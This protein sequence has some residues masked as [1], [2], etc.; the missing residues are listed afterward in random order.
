MHENLIKSPAVEKVAAVYPFRATDYYLELIRDTKNPSLDP[1]GLQCI[2]SEKELEDR[3]SSEDPLAEDHLSPLP[4]IIHKYDDRIVLLATN[5]CAVHCRFCFRKRC[6]KDGAE[7]SDISEEEADNVCRWLKL[8]PRVREVLISGGD[9]LMLSDSK[10]AALLEKL[11]A[12]GVDIVRIGT[13]IPVV[14]PER[15]TENLAK[16]LASFPSIW[17]MT[18]FNHPNEITDK[19]MNACKLLVNSSIPVLNQTVLLK[20]VNDDSETLETLFRALVKNK[21]KP[22]YLFHIDPVKGVRHFATGIEK[23]LEIIKSF[24]KKLSS[25]AVPIFAIDLPDG[26]GK[27]ALQPCLFH[28]GGYESIDGRIIKYPEFK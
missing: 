27:A 1:V 4:R 9:P 13:R 12:S 28:D 20:G 8:N 17:V 3:S 11:F 2:P 7:A 25:I 14:M 6:W 24:R 22:H 10:I 15:I 26:G 5:R 19:S 16:I 21:I 23:G 18:H